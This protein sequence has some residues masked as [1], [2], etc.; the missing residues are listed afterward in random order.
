VTLN[1]KKTYRGSLH[2]LHS[3]V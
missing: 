1:H 2:C 3:A